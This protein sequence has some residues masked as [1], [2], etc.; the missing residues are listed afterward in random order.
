MWQRCGG[1]SEKSERRISVHFSLCL[2]RSAMI[3]LAWLCSDKERFR[4]RVSLVLCLCCVSF[5]KS[6]EQELDW[7]PHSHASFPLGLFRYPMH[8]GC[9]N[10]LSSSCIFQSINCILRFFFHL[11]NRKLKQW[12]E[13]W[14]RNLLKQLWKF[15]TPRCLG[16]FNKQ[17]QGKLEYFYCAN[18][19][20]FE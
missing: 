3:F 12:K 4:L 2:L 10:W 13:L 11:E 20:Y 17:E 14:G 19:T 15:K 6:I 18:D 7:R 8:F 1:D 9:A 5:H 16:N